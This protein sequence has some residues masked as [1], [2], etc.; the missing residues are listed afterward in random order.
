MNETLIA[1]PDLPD[2]AAE[3]DQAHGQAV[4]A[5]GVAIEHARRCGELLT[6][7]KTRIG[8]GGFLD[9]LGKNCRVGERQARNYMR[10]ARNWPAIQAKSEPGSVLT[11]KGALRLMDDRPD[12]KPTEA[13]PIQ[14]EGDAE[15]SLRV[16]G[17][18]GLSDELRPDEHL[19]RITADGKTLLEITPHKQPGYFYV[20][21]YRDLNTDGAEVVYIGRGVAGF[22]VGVAL[23]NF[24]IAPEQLLGTW[25][26]RPFN[27]SAPW[28]ATGPYTPGRFRQ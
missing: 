5:A 18:F 15:R 27:G 20:A 22:A 26:R 7:A 23:R 10:V 11:V 3:I 19:E 2:L 8:H 25:Q 4:A 14:P 9:W 1:L 24:G 12:G 17:L 6:E 13:G 16:N 28:Y 21:A